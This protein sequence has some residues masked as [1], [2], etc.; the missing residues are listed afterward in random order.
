MSFVIIAMGCHSTLASDGTAETLAEMPAVADEIA[1]LKEIS[2]ETVR[3]TFYDLTLGNDNSPA[4]KKTADSFESSGTFHYVDKVG[5]EWYTGYVVL[6]DDSYY[7]IMMDSQGEVTVVKYEQLNVTESE[8]LCN[9]K[10]TG[11]VLPD[12]L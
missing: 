11:M 12:G 5:D 3:N 6:K 2:F 9:R 8:M 1:E 4:V 10:C 7:D